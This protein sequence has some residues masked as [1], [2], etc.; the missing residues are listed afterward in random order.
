MLKGGCS[1]CHNA[2]LSTCDKKKKD[3]LPDTAGVVYVCVRANICRSSVMQ[4]VAI[5]SRGNTKFPVLLRCAG[6]AQF[7]ISKRRCIRFPS[8]RGEHSCNIGITFQRVSTAFKINLTKDHSPQLCVYLCRC[9]GVGG[10]VDRC[11]AVHGVAGL[12]R[13]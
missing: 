3:P 1:G 12:T 9:S 10:P 7:T 5:C 13:K 6:T 4:V 11:A 8:H 2:V